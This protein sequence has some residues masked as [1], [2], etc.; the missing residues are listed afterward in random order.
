MYYHFTG[1]L[2]FFIY[3]IVTSV[4]LQGIYEY[5]IDKMKFEKCLYNSKPNRIQS[6]YIINKI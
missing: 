5:S 6:A 2:S 1:I 4:H 3:C